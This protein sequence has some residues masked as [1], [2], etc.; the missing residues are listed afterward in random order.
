MNIFAI[1]VGFLAGLAF[2]FFAGWLFVEYGWIRDD[3]VWRTGVGVLAGGFAGAIGGSISGDANRATDSG[4]GNKV[5]WGL[6]MGSLGGALGGSKL[7][8]I[9]SA[10]LNMGINSPI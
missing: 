9:R 10:L 3:L 8:I 4:G 1:I 2:G 5:L 6:I 7:D